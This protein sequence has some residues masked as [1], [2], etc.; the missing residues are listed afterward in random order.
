MVAS[1]TKPQVFYTP[2]LDLAVPSPLSP[3]RLGLRKD[4]DDTLC[5][6]LHLL[7][8]TTTALRQRRRI[9]QILEHV[10]TAH[11]LC[12]S[13]NDLRRSLVCLLRSAP[14]V[15][16][17][18][19]HDVGN[20]LRYRLIVCCLRVVSVYL[21][22]LSQDLISASSGCSR[23]LANA[24]SS[25]ARFLNAS[26]RS[27]DSATH[28]SNSAN[29]FRISSVDI[30]STSRTEDTWVKRPAGPPDYLLP[31]RRDGGISFVLCFL[32]S[33]G[34]SATPCK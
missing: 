10:Q 11:H 3:R 5:C 13:S 20:L 18:L 33:T 2:R 1:V 31:E 29:E 26:S 27:R 8:G 24:T 23:A 16:D 32:S 4:L 28:R 6:H 14:L 25:A 21:R 12:E 9:Q 34:L 19:G 22:R 7:G 30:V 17:V 15:F